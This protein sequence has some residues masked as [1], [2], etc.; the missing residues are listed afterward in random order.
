ME[1]ALPTSVTL[2]PP[3]VMP[4]TWLLTTTSA[5]FLPSRAAATAAITPPDVPPKTQTSQSTTL[6]PARA[7]WQRMTEEKTKKKATTLN[8]F[9]RQFC[10]KFSTAAQQK[11]VP[12]RAVL[13]T[14]C[15]SWV[16]IAAQPFS[17]ALAVSVCQPT[18]S[19]RP[20]R[21]PSSFLS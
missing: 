20:I 11:S 13:L 1:A 17:T 21:L 14:P 8:N 9:T 16:F 19:L 2:K 18:A 5:T 3:D 15:F 12:C 6:V 4:P 10:H 7:V